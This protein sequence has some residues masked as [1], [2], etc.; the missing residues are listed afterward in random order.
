M[1]KTV[2]ILACLA[3]LWAAPLWADP[4]SDPAR[5]VVALER[6]AMD[7]WLHGDPGPQLAITDPEITYI[8][9]VAGTRLEGLAAL[10]DLYERY[11]GMPLFD[12]YEIL[13]PKVHATPGMAV[14]TYRLARHNGSAVEYWN[15][16]EVFVKRP[17]GWR[18]VH[19]HWSAAK[20]RQL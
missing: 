6:Q 7:G 12:S 17:E 18:I 3:G 2:S 4:A 1:K 9:D 15:G 13:N 11:R 14:L 19:T 5:E 10:R 8:H 16:T 20:D